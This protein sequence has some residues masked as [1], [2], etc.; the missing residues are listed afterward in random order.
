MK[1]TARLSFYSELAFGFV[2]LLYTLANFLLVLELPSNLI[3]GLAVLLSISLIILNTLYKRDFYS[4]Y[5]EKKAD[6]VLLISLPLIFLFFNQNFESEFLGFILVA[7]LS[8]LAIFNM[9]NSDF[10]LLIFRC[11]FYI[12]LLGVLL[13]IIEYYFFE[14]SYFNDTVE[15]YPYSASGT[16]ISFSGFMYNYNSVTYFVICYMALLSFQ[17]SDIRDYFLPIVILFLMFSKLLI[18]FLLLIVLIKFFKGKARISLSL[19]AIMS[20]LILSN[21]V[22]VEEGTYPYPSMYFREILT[23]YMSWD[24][25]L[26]LHGWLKQ[27][28]LQELL[29]GASNFIEFENKYSYQPHSSLISFGLLGGIFF[30]FLFVGNLIIVS[31]RILNQLDISD[32]PI[33][34]AAFLAFLIELINW[35]FYDSFYFWIVFFICCKNLVKI[36]SNNN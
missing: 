33:L 5:I 20:Y 23:S 26:S 27:Q 35:D 7:S 14:S 30:L 18:L 21:V 36:K 19:F 4:N 24:L 2:I 28:G 16:K 17:N 6:L 3:I 1:Q 25:V 9:R 11:I 15:F 34:Y 29:V 10:L 13:G 32:A 22:I 31:F 12:V 8:Y